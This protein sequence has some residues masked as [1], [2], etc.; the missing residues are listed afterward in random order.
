MNVSFEIGSLVEFTLV[1][2]IVWL[3]FC[4]WNNPW[5]FNYIA[6]LLYSILKIIILFRCNEISIKVLVQQTNPIFIYEKKTIKLNWL[7]CSKGVWKDNCDCFKAAKNTKV[8]L[9]KKKY[10]Y[11]ECM[12]A[13]KKEGKKIKNLK[14]S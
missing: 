7:F 12:N 6:S 5:Y 11:Y 3:F 8:R 10:Q 1:K 4:S 13:K 14:N 2:A 9:Q